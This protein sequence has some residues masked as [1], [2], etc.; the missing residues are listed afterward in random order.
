MNSVDFIGQ[1]ADMLKNHSIVV[2]DRS[3]LLKLF[4]N[5]VDLCTNTTKAKLKAAIKAESA[6]TA[7]A[8]APKKKMPVKEKLVGEMNAG[9][10]PVI[11]DITPGK[12]TARGRGRP[13]KEVA[14]VQAVVADAVE[15]E[16]KKRGR[17]KKEKSLVMSSNDD[18][19]ALIAQML[20]Q[21]KSHP[22]SQ[23]SSQSSSVSPI[24]TAVSA[25]LEP[26]EVEQDVA[27]DATDD[28]T[29]DEQPPAPKTT[30]AKAKAAAK[31]PKTKA[32]AKE[33][34]AAAK[35]PKAANKEPKAAN[36]EPK[37]ANKE[38]K[39]AKESN[40][41]N[42]EPKAANKEPKAKE[43]NAKEPN[44][45]ESNAKESNAKESNAKEP[46]TV[47]AEAD[48][49]VAES[50]ATLAAEYPALNVSVSACSASPIRETKAG[51]DGN[52]YLMKNFPRSSFTYNGKTYLRTETDN[53]Y[54]SLTMELIGVWDH[55]NHE[56]ITPNDDDVED[57]DALWSDEE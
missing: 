27:A 29:D 48:R 1:F 6:D 3:T 55:L 11:S 56:I 22:M 7:A 30:K 26:I 17:P 43:S 15:G 5:V 52:F 33:P 21:M 42:K 23:S 41:A 25:P 47:A 49:I 19:D 34:K 31:E 39:A 13:R 20:G 18:E 16:K 57:L 12:P 53:V 38:P 8:A 36:K 10:C 46:K 50:L 9:D 2:N 44:A 37:A 28:V 35:E 45:K 14:V 51:S 4:E 40:A 54:D 32:A 24:L